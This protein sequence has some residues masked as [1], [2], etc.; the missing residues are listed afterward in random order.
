MFGFKKPDWV[1][2]LRFSVILLK[3]WGA[4]GLKAAST[5]IVLTPELPVI[6]ILCNTIVIDV[7]AEFRKPCERTT[8]EFVLVSV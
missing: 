1:S 6:S 5:I 3:P 8:L 2:N 7:G 4:Q